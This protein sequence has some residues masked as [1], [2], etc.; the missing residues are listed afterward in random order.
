MVIMGEN[1][2]AA[3]FLIGSSSFLHVTMTTIKSRISSKFGQ[4]RS[5]TVELA[6]PVRLK[7]FPWSYNGRNVVASLA[8]SFL[9]G[10]SSVLQVRKTTIKSRVSLKFGQI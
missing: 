6:G 7:K 5:Q 3:S 2:V 9:I 4:I 1:A 10:S 8:P